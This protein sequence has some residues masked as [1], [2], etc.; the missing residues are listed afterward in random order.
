M[1]TAFEQGP[2]RPP[3]EARSLLV[4]VTRNCPWNRCAFCPVYKGR[5]YGARST[6]EIL[7]DLDAMREAADRVHALSR[8]LGAGGAVSQTVLERVHASFEHRDLL[9]VAWWL[10]HGGR[11]VFLQDANA[12]ASPRNKLLAVLAGIR[13]RFPDVDRI[14]TYSQTRTLARKPVEQL[15][16]YREA[17]LTRIHVGLES[18]SDAVLG[19]VDKG[20]TAAVHVEGGRRVVAA[21]LHLC[22]YVMPGLGGV[23]LSADHARATAEVLTAIQPA[24]VRLRSL[25]VAPRTPLGERVERGEFETLPE[26]GMVAEIRA[27]LGGMEGVHARLVSDHDLNLLPELEG[28]L[29]ADLPRLLAVCDRFLGW[30]ALDRNRFVLGRRAGLVGSVA[31]LDEEGVRTH[32]DG[33]AARLGVDLAAPIDG[34]IDQLR[35]RMV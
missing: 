20:A 35:R 6:D 11:T 27:L 31:D 33:A 17:G 29:P 28:Q 23:G 9:P 34:W 16:A 4:R 24:A 19:L 2:I 3:S 18:G 10:A 25:V 8:S 21:G 30:E 26:D 14:T 13:E 32:I 7:A 12:I 5:D 1:T 15:V 22:C